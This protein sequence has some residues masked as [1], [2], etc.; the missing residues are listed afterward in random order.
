MSVV[1]HTKKSNNLLY[2]EIYSQTR[3]TVPHIL[4]RV[5]YPLLKLYLSMDRSPF[6]SE[7]ILKGCTLC[8]TA[9]L[10]TNGPLQDSMAQHTVLNVDT[11]Q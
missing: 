4:V 1:T 5:G 6:Q 7:I 2:K 8:I 10:T 3:N 9:N 11:V